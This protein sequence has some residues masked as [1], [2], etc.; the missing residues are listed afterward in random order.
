MRAGGLS[1]I[2]PGNAS[3]AT[4]IGSD[5]VIGG[6][7]GWG[8][9]EVLEGFA[10]V[11]VGGECGG[12]GVVEVVVPVVVVEDQFGAAVVVEVAEDRAAGFRW[13]HEFEVRQALPI[14]A[15]EVR[16][17]PVPRPGVR[18]N[19]EEAAG[20]GPGEKDRP[21]TAQVGHREH[22]LAVP[23]DPNLVQPFE[24]IHPRRHNLPRIGA[25]PV[26][27]LS[28]DSLRRGREAWWEHPR[29]LNRGTICRCNLRVCGKS[30]VFSNIFRVQESA[31]NHG[32][33]SYIS[34]RNLL[35]QS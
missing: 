4:V 21:E 25:E 33:R 14:R 2:D 1:K 5:T 30:R 32:G 27:V 17:N 22:P 20:I 34:L 16:P 8:G 3:R 11:A 10:V 29:G 26:G 23:R 15:V 9:F 24:L 28:E 19:R 18:G 31:R 35:I 7:L 6:A 12:R 13:D